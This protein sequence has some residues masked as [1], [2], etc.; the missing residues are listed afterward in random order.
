MEQDRLLI[1]N[2]LMQLKSPY[3]IE[4]IPS[5]IIQQADGDEEENDAK[6][7]KKVMQSILTKGIKE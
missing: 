2:I 6:I 5:D 7:P 1:E 4:D 3:N